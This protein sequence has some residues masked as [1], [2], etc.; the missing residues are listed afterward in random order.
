M[1]LNM[2]SWR[3]YIN[4]FKLAENFLLDSPYNLDAIHL[5]QFLGLKIEADEASSTRYYFY[6]ERLLALNMK[7][8][9]YSCSLALAKKRLKLV[10]TVLKKSSFHLVLACFRG[11][12]RLWCLSILWSSPVYKCIRW[13]WFRLYWPFFV[14]WLLSSPTM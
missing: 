14:P 10:E 8:F 2:K 9:S 1:Y 5:S 7:T 12:S 4:I 6:V 3:V 13:L 11:A